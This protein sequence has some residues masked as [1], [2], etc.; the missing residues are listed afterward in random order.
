MSA[1]LVAALGAVV[2]GEVLVLPVL[3]QCGFAPMVNRGFEHGVIDSGGAD[4]ERVTVL[5]AAE[6][7]RFVLNVH[8]R[9]TDVRV[10]ER[11]G[12]D[13]EKLRLRLRVPRSAGTVGDCRRVD[14]RI[15]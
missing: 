13:G 1:K 10:V 9:W 7:R 3:E 8:E 4:E 2:S 14:H 11:H 6:R 5:E 15:S 12:R